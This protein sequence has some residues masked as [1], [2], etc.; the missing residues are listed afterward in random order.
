MKA[1]TCISL[2]VPENCEVTSN[3]FTI[4]KIAQFSPVVEASSLAL[5]KIYKIEETGIVMQSSAG[6]HHQLMTLKIPDRA[7]IQ[8]IKKHRDNLENKLNTIKISGDFDLIDRDILIFWDFSDHFEPL[9]ITGL[10]VGT[11]CIIFTLIIAI[12]VC[13][14]L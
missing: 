6:Q 14:H 7:L 3:Y 8:Q 11:F 10:S 12:I 5:N 9:S 4:K 1:I 13:K 2:A